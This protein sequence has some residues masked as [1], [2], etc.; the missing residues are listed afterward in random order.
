ML[1]DLRG[2]PALFIGCTLPPFGHDGACRREQFVHGALMIGAGDSGIEGDAH[3]S[4]CDGMV[5][6]YTSAVALA[7]PDRK[8]LGDDSICCTARVI[9]HVI[10]LALLADSTH[11]T[12]HHGAA[13]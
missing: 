3:A 2:R 12:L 1:R 9:A 10:R 6:G 4:P 8:I 7:P 5:E 11:N 13:R